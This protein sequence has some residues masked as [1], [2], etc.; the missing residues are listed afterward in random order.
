MERNGSEDTSIEV[1]LNEPDNIFIPRKDKESW[2]E[3][4]PRE[5]EGG[6]IRRREK[7]EGR[8]EVYF[9]GKK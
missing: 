3:N 5:R 6:R 8:S 2:L 9:L 7:R 4:S 1:K